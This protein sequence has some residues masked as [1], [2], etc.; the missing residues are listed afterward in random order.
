M[1]RLLEVFC[2]PAQR[3]A[4][5]RWSSPQHVDDLDRLEQDEDPAS[6]STLLQSQGSRWKPAV[7]ELTSSLPVSGKTSLLHLITAL[8]VLPGDHGGQGTAVVWLDTDGRFSVMRLRE[9]ILDAVSS[10]TADEGTITGENDTESLVQEALTHVHVLRPK[11]SQQLIQTLDSLPSYLLDAT[12]HS[13]ISRRLG[14]L[15]L[16]AASAFYWQDRYH[17]ETARF[18]HPDQPRDRPSRT[19]EVITKLRNF[20][21]GFD[22]AI[23]YSTSSAFTTMNKPALP[24]TADS[25]APHESRSASAWNRFA[26][27]TLNL[28]RVSVVRF[29]SHMS[30]EQCLRDQE[31]RQHAV[32]KAD[33]VAEVDRSEIATWTASVKEVWGEMEAGGGFRFAFAPT[34]PVE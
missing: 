29:P 26:S 23:A 18:K 19:A 17:S 12:A 2:A 15:V 4:A 9:V 25:A 1:D 3:L 28:S 27:L 21:R 6:H 10:P 11:S 32:T 20:Q 24:S 34:V 14:L 30:L 5:P 22:C 33:F 7:I 13:S 8:S 16:D 31:K